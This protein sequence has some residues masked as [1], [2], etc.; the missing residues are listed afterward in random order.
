MPIITRLHT[1]DSLG[2]YQFFTT[3]ALVLAPFASGS[4]Q[5]AISSAKTRYRALANL[6]LAMQFSLIFFAIFLLGSFFSIPFLLQSSLEWFAWYTPLVVFFVYVSANFQFAM[7]YLTNSQSYSHQSTYSI[8]KSGISNA[9]KLAFSYFSKS[10]FSLVL[11]IVLTEV[12]QI[13]GLIRNSHRTIFRSIFRFNF[14]KF[15]RR[16]GK[17]RR[18]PTYV[19]LTSVLS[20]LMNW[21]PILM[22][23]FFTVQNT[24]AFLALHLWSLTRQFTLL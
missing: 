7:A 14:E 11:A 22:T 9:L 21:F 10:G 20:I 18:Y 8:T 24:Q 3:V 5:F 12:L 4:F 16:I 13:F 19:T 2:Q 1:P 6:K 15:K 17:E 23:G